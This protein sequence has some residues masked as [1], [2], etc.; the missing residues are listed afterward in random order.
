MVK[1]NGK[2]RSLSGKTI[3]ELL[4]LDGYDRKKV[5]VEVDLEIVPKAKY[6]ETVLKDGCSVE[7]VSFVGGG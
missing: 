3:A 6:D 4:E 1:V 7:I 5:A 2:E